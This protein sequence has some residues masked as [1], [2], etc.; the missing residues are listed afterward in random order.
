MRNSL[1][2][3][4]FVLI[5]GEKESLLFIYLFLYTY[6]WFIKIYNIQT[7]YAFGHCTLN[8]PK[9]HRT[10]IFLNTGPLFLKNRTSA[11][12]S[13]CLQWKKKI[14]ETTQILQLV[15]KLIYCGWPGIYFVI[16]I[17]AQ[18]LSIFLYFLSSRLVANVANNL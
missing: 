11:N 5:L 13:P 15:Q 1:F 16:R 14:I 4:F 2:F 3:S 8:W 6:A 17:F 7:C 12:W 18:L 9:E 10:V